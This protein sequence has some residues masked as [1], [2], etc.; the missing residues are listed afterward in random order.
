M[1]IL[2]KKNKSK[3]FKVVLHEIDD[4]GSG[5]KVLEDTETGI[6]YLFHYTP[7]GAGLTVLRDEEG[8]P[9]IVPEQ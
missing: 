6:T 7:E 3:R 9:D 8:E 5:T 1:V 4:D 2:K